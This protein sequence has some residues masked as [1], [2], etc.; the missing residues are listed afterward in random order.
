MLHSCISHF[1]IYWRWSWKPVENSE[2]SACSELSVLIKCLINFLTS[3]PINIKIHHFSHSTTRQYSSAAV[4]AWRYFTEAVRPGKLCSEFAKESE[5][6]TLCLLYRATGA[7]ENLGIL[8]FFTGNDRF[9]AR[10][11]ERRPNLQRERYIHIYIYHIMAQT[12]LIYG[13]KLDKC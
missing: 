12:I 7:W 2:V 1:L 9:L 4:S 8:R 5:Y 3:A 11:G 13:F 10:N 6:L